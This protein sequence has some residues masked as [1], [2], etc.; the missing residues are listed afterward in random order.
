MFDLPHMYTLIL[1]LRP[2]L[3]TLQIPLEQIER[4]RQKVICPTCKKSVIRQTP[5][6][7]HK[8]W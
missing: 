3:V 5:A 6:W 2:G 4:G 8:L 7:Y 1:I